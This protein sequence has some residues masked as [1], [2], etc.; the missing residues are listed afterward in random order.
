MMTAQCSADMQLRSGWVLLNLQAARA[1]RLPYP[2]LVWRPPLV[3]NEGMLSAC[4]TRVRD[5]S[6]CRHTHFSPSSPERMH[7]GTLERLDVHEVGARGAR[8]ASTSH[9]CW[10]QLHSDTQGADARL[11]AMVLVLM[12]QDSTTGTPAGVHEVF[13]SLSRP[14]ALAV[15]STFVASGAVVHTFDRAHSSHLAHAIAVPLHHAVAAAL[16][17]MQ[18]R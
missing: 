8:R 18:F 5:Y 12:L 4:A 15:R 9:A 7:E 16:F 17:D 13:D 3:V 10:L 1:D 11:A 6:D 2:P 14:D